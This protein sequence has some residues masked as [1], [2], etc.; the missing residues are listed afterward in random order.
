MAKFWRSSEFEALNKEWSQKLTEAG[1]EDC[2][3]E[4]A[5]QRVLKQS[6]DYAYRRKECTEIYRESKLTYFML[7]AE[8]L[9]KEKNFDDESDRL[10][11]S[12]TAEGWTIKE[13]SRELRRLGKIKHNRD[14]IRY[15]RRRYENRWGI[16]NWKTE[17]MVSR[18]VVTR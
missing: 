1:F 3:K 15:I 16:K 4:I 17:Q 2:E 13:I 11:M 14:T 7:L 12:W 8:H 10:I 9:T 5:G 18:R 6:A